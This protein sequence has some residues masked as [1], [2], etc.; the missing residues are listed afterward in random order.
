MVE[1]N[2]LLFYSIKLLLNIIANRI[3]QQTVFSNTHDTCH[4]IHFCSA[5]PNLWY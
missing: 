5:G 1:F 4:K 3:C 2:D